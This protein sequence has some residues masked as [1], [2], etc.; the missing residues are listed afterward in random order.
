MDDIICQRLTSPRFPLALTLY[1]CLDASPPPVPLGAHQAVRAK[2]NETL[3]LHH[4]Q[5]SAGIGGKGRRCRHDALF[6]LRSYGRG[7]V[8]S[9][10]WSV[11]KRQDQD[12]HVGACFQARNIP[13]RLSAFAQDA[14]LNG[15]Q[16]A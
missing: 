13:E 6:L 7:P 9:H 8:Q 15:A 5:E 14:A 16:E 12:Q 11:G 2:H 1:S 10:Q 3:G 4:I